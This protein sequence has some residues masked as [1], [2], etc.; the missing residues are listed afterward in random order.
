MKDYDYVSRDCP[1]FSFIELKKSWVK[2]NKNC[3]IYD[4]LFGFL[5]DNKKIIEKAIS[6]SETII[7]N[8]PIK[9]EQNDVNSE[10]DLKIPDNYYN[11]LIIYYWYKY[12]QE[13]SNKKYGFNN[14][15]SNIDKLTKIN[16]YDEQFDFKITQIIYSLNKIQN[17][18]NKIINELNEIN[19]KTNLFNNEKPFKFIEYNK[20]KY[21]QIDKDFIFFHIER[22]YE[23][24]PNVKTIY[25][26]IRLITKEF[27]KK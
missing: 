8:L 2:F 23:H 18:I 10:D 27:L 11:Y 20:I 17:I 26:A 24:I 6:D 19:I 7:K 21:E 15:K 1:S 5:K 9:D 3:L 14:F 13:N 4:H 25:S 22:I 16:D 12:L